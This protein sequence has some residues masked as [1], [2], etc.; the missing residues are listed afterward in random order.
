M[1]TS[2]GDQGKASDLLAVGIEFERV[3]VLTLVELGGGHR[4]SKLQEEGA[5]ETHHEWLETSKTGME[6]LVCCGLCSGR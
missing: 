5:A 6:K 1:R 2:R 3:S 4:G